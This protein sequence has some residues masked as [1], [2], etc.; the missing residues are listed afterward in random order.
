MEPSN[1][2]QV[3]SNQQ[4]VILP[5]EEEG[6]D[7]KKYIFLI[8][9]H[10]WWFAI[11]VFISLTIAY[12]INRYS[13][14]VYSASCSVIVGEERSGTGTIEGV[15]D[16]LSRLRNRRRK[17]VVENEISILKSY[18]MTRLALEDL[19]FYITY[20][21]VGRRGI[22]ET[23][24]YQHSPFI[25]KY[26][27]TETNLY[28]YPINI[29]FL[30]NNE[31]RLII[32][33]R[34]DINKVMQ[35]GEKFAHESFN[36]NLRL[37]DPDN[38]NFESNISKKYYFTFNDI[39]SLS[40][41]YQKALNV[42]VNDEKG[43][44]LTLSMQ[45]FVD[46][47]LAD[48]LNRL[49]EVYIR[50]NLEEKNITS[51]NTIQFIDEQL[52]GIVDSLESTGLRLQQFRTT[53]KV[54]DLSK[55]GIFLFEK[56]QE[57][58]SEKA[59][60]DIKTNYYNYLLDYVSNKNASGDLVA[61]SVVG[62]QDNLLNSIVA[63]INELNLQKRQM[64][65]SASESSP[66]LALINSQI[67]NAKEALKEN[68]RSLIES[69]RIALEN[70]N[71]RIAKIE[72]DVQKLPGT[73]RQMIDIQRKFT[74]NDQIYTFM[75]EKRAEAGITRASNISD[76]KILDIARS[77]N[78]TTVKPKTS[79]NY[80][81]ALISGGAIPL[82][83]IL[84]INFFNTRITDKKYLEESL[85]APIIGNIGH[86]DRGTELPV[87]ENPRSSL[88][89]SFRALRTNLQYILQE[90]KTGVIAVTS[91]V[92]NEGK[93]FCAVN[94]AGIIAISGKKTL[95]ISLDLRKPKIHRIFNLN[96]TEGISTYLIGKSDYNNMI[97]ET[98]IANLFVTTSG[99]IPP[100]PAEL[101]GTEKMKTFI[102]KAKEDFEYI[103]IDTPPV[104]IVTDTLVLKDFL[105][106][107][108]FVV[109]HNYSDKQVV[110]LANSMY[111]K[112]LIK[113]LGVVVNDI[114]LKG[115][116]GYSYRYGYGYGYGY[117][118]SYRQ[119]YYDEETKNQSLWYTFKKR[120]NL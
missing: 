33:D 91:A 38:Y 63:E 36:F 49:M 10:W 16:E 29:L 69:N 119:A 108:I 109:R 113:S 56:M 95:L 75:L 83:L 17:A 98:N 87:T 53:H 92:S 31:Y 22:A 74:I 77:E 3:T 101:L 40:N 7:I 79:M 71:T 100:N 42:E 114:Q 59:I 93:T 51:E 35:F 19:D 37:R 28:N 67:E 57:L 44:I 55:E 27:T 39:N 18:K 4:Q 102:Q 96:N 66:Q 89:E 61:P 68:L 23:Q 82:A 47:Q 94:L 25:V 6:I 60:Y 5:E 30:S 34:H 80:L 64:E 118:Y 73:E 9:Y 88:A 112:H 78:A 32:D 72:N 52:S 1:Q 70:L 65:F 43:T 11:A 107:L 120:F 90:K 110:E 24:L 8:L 58:Q 50:A 97:F 2:Q 14:E 81:I 12:L 21:A 106:S 105:D 111:E 26:D 62:I 117:S 46:D 54:I 85:K 41:Y 13:Q 103:I 76:H 15:L 86:N 84:L 116:Y 45:G 48:Y 115:Y 104:A 20:T 99:P